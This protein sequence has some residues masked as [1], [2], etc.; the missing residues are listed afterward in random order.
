MKAELLLSGDSLTIFPQRQ[1]RKLKLGS[2]SHESPNSAVSRWFS[3]HSKEAYQLIHDG[4]AL[5]AAKERSVAP[6]RSN[7]GSLTL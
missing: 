4:K 1:S 6:V 3:T 2:L 5:V 7:S